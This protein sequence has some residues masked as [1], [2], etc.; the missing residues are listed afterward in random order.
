M[1]RNQL[2]FGKNLNGL[3]WVMK[4]CVIFL[5]VQWVSVIV[6]VIVLKFFQIGVIFEEVIVKMVGNQ[7]ELVVNVELRSGVEQMK[8]VLRKMRESDVMKKDIVGVINFMIILEEYVIV[9]CVIVV[10][11]MRL[12]FG[13]LEVICLGLVLGFLELEWI[14]RR[15]CLFYWSV[16]VLGVFWVQV[17]QFKDIMCEVI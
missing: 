8:G 2:V 14:Y 3:F 10:V 4:D 12:R 13:L 6:D 7:L 16:L 17:F 15:V 9:I 11:I 5:V 1:F